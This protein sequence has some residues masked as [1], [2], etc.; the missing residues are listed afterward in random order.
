M[1]VRGQGRG[2]PVADI[3]DAGI[4]FEHLELNRLAG[5]LLRGR[6]LVVGRT[7]SRYCRCWR[8][9][10]QSVLHVSWLIVPVALVNAN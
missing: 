6:G 8:D 7:Q 2:L 9:L 5:E 10:S 3:N 4:G 1:H